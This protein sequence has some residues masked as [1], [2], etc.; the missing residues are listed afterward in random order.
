[1]I[2]LLDQFHP[3]IG[4]PMDSSIGAF[5]YTIKRAENTIWSADRAKPT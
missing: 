4:L 2:Y 5:H 3:A 1:M